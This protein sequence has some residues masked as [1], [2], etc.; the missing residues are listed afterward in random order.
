MNVCAKM[1]CPAS[2]SKRKVLRT[3]PCSRQICQPRSQYMRVGGF[4][5]HTL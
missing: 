5:S 1:F 2:E 4:S 3:I